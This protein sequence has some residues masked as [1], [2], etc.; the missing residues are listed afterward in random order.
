MDGGSG[1]SETSDC[2]KLAH[3]VR[4][5]SSAADDRRVSSEAKA[6]FSCPGVSVS[7]RLDHCHSMPGRRE[8]APTR[9]RGSRACAGTIAA[10]PGNTPRKLSPTEDAARCTSRR[11]QNQ[12]CCVCQPFGNQNGSL[13]Y[14]CKLDASVFLGRLNTPGGTSLTLSSTRLRC[15]PHHACTPPARPIGWNSALA[16]VHLPRFSLVRR[17]CCADPLRGHA[18]LFGLLA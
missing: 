8:P 18:Q 11:A 5:C 2:V 6:C 4:P 7:V 17:L 12:G 3:K 15:R 13:S 9:R 16:T 10:A 1:G 14:D